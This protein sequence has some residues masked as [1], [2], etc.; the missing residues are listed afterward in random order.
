[1]VSNEKIVVL[2]MI[3]FLSISIVIAGDLSKVGV[4]WDNVKQFTNDETTSKY[5]KYEIRNTMLG[6]PFWKLGK[7][8]DIELK[9]NSDSCGVDC[10][11]EKE[12]TLYNDGI[13][14]DQIKFKTLQS[15]DSWKE[16]NIRS[17]ELSYQKEGKKIIYNLGDVV[18]S[19]TYILRLD[20]RKKPSRTIDWIIKSNGVWTNEWAVWQSF[21]ISVDELMLYYN[22][23]ETS[24]AILDLSGNSR[25]GIEYNVINN[26]D[27]IVEK[28]LKFN[29]T[30]SQYINTTW[31]KDVDFD[32]SISF[33]FWIN[34]TDLDGASCIVGTEN[35]FTCIGLTNQKKMTF[36]INS[37]SGSSTIT[38]DINITTNKWNLVV[39]T[40][41]G[42][43]MVLYFKNETNTYSK[44]QGGLSGDLTIAGNFRV[45][46]DRG[47]DT[48]G[49][50]G[51]NG[52]IDEIS[53]WNRSLSENEVNLLWNNGIGATYDSSLSSI[54]LNSPN[55]DNVTNINLISFST[56]ATVVGGSTL[57]NMSLWNNETGS[58]EVRNITSG[59]S[60]TSSTQIWN[61][62]MMKGEYIWG[63]VA[64]D[65][66]GDCGFSL[67]NNTLSI[68]MNAPTFVVENPTGVLNFSSIGNSET[69]NI[70]F[71][72]NNLEDCWYDYNSTNYTIDGCLT[73]IKNSTTFVMEED[74]FNMTI[75]ANDSVGN[76]NI[77]NINWTYIVFK[78]SENFTSS[79]TEGDTSNFSINVTWLSESFS[80]VNAYLN[81][82]GS[83]QGL[84]T[85]TLQGDNAYFI[86]EMVTPSVDVN[87][88]LSWLW[89]FTVEGIFYNSSAQ[90]QT[91]LNINFDN[92]SSYSNVLFNFSLKDE[93]ENLF[94]NGTSNVSLIEAELTIFGGGLKIFDFAHQYNLINP[95]TICSDEDLSNSSYTFDLVVGFSSTDRVNE[96]YFIDSGIIS[97]STIPFEIDLMNLKTADS[98]SFLFNYFDVDG[99]AVTNTI[100]NVF[101]KYIGD[102]IFREVERG[103]AD[104]NGDTIIHLVE[105][106]VIYYFE[107]TQY[108][109]SLFTSDEYTALCQTTPCTL[110]LEAS[111][112]GATF[113]TDWDLVDDGA[114]TV[115]S[116]KGTRIVNLT[117]ATTG[118]STFNL[119]VYRYLSDGN[120][121]VVNTSSATGT[122]RVILISVPQSAGN[123]TFFATVIKDDDFINSEWVNFEADAQ[124]R[125]GIT[126][127]LFLGALIILSL[128]LMAVTEGVGTLVFVM[129]GVIIAGALGL[130]TTSLSSGVNI[131]IYLII[132][133]GI[134]LWKLTGGRK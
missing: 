95:A 69:L 56:T 17:Y 31:G 65:S 67:A 134:L 117:F 110:Q 112:V 68:D 121:T 92:C 15:D 119:T 19:G 98:T 10:F 106:D 8:M 42:N 128:G 51:F 111:G 103:K 124:D 9:N 21:P 127:A 4:D 2:F 40:Y 30:S 94:L 87:V 126:L 80:D 105:E 5:G 97:N 89:E 72:D 84:A 88:N 20:G 54:V 120:Y 73:S 75:Y 36:D 24:G 85:R 12:I 74:N 78:L 76:I 32:D 58:W 34:S 91:V 130:V 53:I 102:G 113:P 82:N 122:S 14:V 1:M 33:V 86:S 63:V 46:K 25:N 11:A 16:Q 43:E 125:F 3:L 64:C 131:I 81:Y 59:L 60:G 23:N 70:T 45:G 41:D 47:Y 13:L 77:T 129:L 90:N 66:D 57:V 35:E 28:A 7:V 71:T 55:N 50:R 29:E 44:T 114:Y 118:T 38:M 39:G 96:F 100:V 99:L 123:V 83:R 6:I 62:T 27:G 93:E 133:G 79:V 18:P 116:N 107:I 108:G 37:I 104:N 49:I 22:L 61:R 26:A 101:R 109:V 48:T 132:A 115:S 52:T